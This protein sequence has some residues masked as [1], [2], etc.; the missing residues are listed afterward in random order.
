MKPNFQNH[1][2]QMGEKKYVK[3]YTDVISTLLSCMVRNEKCGCEWRKPKHTSR[4]YA[5]DCLNHKI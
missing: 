5:E 2:I 4:G 1:N 3:T